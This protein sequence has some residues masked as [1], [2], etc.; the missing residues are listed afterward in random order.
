MDDLHVE[1]NKE[2]HHLLFLLLPSNRKEHF[3][4]DVDV[5][6]DVD[7]EFDFQYYPNFG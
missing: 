3:D 6:F 2:C 4:I 1:N 5:E 7:C